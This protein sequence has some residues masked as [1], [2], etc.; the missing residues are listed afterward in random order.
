MTTMR[1]ANAGRVTEP[2]WTGGDLATDAARNRTE[3][4]QRAAR[5]CESTHERPARPTLRAQDN[6]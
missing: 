1:I 2:I 6:R 4:P 3:S 5:G